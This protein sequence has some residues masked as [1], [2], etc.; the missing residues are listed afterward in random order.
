M[1]ILGF[2]CGAIVG[3]VATASFAM[4]SLGG[5]LESGQREEDQ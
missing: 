3:I 1:F 2:L 5:G 4:W